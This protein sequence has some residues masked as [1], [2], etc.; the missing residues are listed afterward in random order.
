MPEP[1]TVIRERE[2]EVTASDVGV[3]LAVLF[4]ND[5]GEEPAIQVRGIF[6]TAGEVL[7]HHGDAV[8]AQLFFD[9]AC[10]R[11]TFASALTKVFADACAEHGNATSVKACTSGAL[12]VVV[13]SVFRT[14][15]IHGTVV[16]VEHHHGENLGEAFAENARIVCMDFGCSV[17]VGDNPDGVA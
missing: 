12:L 5:F 7:S 8:R 15:R 11:G 9:H 13:E 2:F 4:G 16:P 3:L 6:A 17:G 1:E 14:V 10:H